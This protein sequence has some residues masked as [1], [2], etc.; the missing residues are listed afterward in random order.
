M[1]YQATKTWGSEV[2][3]SCC[4]RQ[5]RA[6]HSH[7]RF[8]HGYALGVRIVFAA[9]TLDE[10]HWVYNFGG[11]KWIRN[12]LVEQFDHT[13]VIAADDPELALFENLAARNLIQLRI[14]P[15]VGCEMF[16]DWIFTQIAPLIQ[17]ETAGRVSV[18]SVEVFEHGANSALALA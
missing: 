5:W 2:G 12:K 1:I 14:M 9:S 15:A 10:R 8:L 16:A 13:T 17:T 11:L 18:K 7:C 6:T 3:L 4:F